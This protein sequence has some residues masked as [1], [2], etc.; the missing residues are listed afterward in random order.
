MLKVL[1]RQDKYRLGIFYLAS[2]A[3]L[4]T[5]PLIVG[6]TTAAFEVVWLDDASF[7]SGVDDD[8]SIA[9]DSWDPNDRGLDPTEPGPD[10][11]R[12]AEDNS[13]CSVVFTDGGSTLTFAI[14]DGRIGY[15][16]TWRSGIQNVG[17][18][19]AKLQGWTLNGPPAGEIEARMLSACG[20]EI[21]ASSG[22]NVEGYFA[23][24]ASSTPGT[25]YAGSFDLEWIE[26]GSWDVADCPS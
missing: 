21:V 11:A 3:W 24:D 25:N 9:A 2:A 19:D 23:I 22:G 4:S 8:D 18:I 26:A 1:T 13:S 7:P 20:L 12:G 14:A 15:F 10:G 5:L 16:C 6:I 17:D